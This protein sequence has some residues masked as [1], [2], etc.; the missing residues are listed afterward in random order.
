MMICLGVFLFGSNFF[1]TL[2]AF[3]TSWKSISFTKLGKE[4][5][6]RKLL[7]KLVQVLRGPRWDGPSRQK[8]W[9]SG[10][11]CVSG[12]EARGWWATLKGDVRPGFEAPPVSSQPGFHLWCLPHLSLSLAPFCQVD[13]L[14]LVWHLSQEGFL[15]TNQPRKATRPPFVSTPVPSPLPGGHAMDP[16]L[17]GVA[18]VFWGETGEWDREGH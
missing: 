8:D 10:F 11:C 13:P 6:F 18:S 15:Q 14:T 7:K 3:W 5:Q 12:V 16:V 9:C 1:G 17:P 2:W 4:N